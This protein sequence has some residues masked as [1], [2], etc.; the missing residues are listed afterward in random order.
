MPITINFPSRFGRMCPATYHSQWADPA[1]SVGPGRSNIRRFEST[2]P[3][4]VL[5]LQLFKNGEPQDPFSNEGTLDVDIPNN[6]VTTIVAAWTIRY[7]EDPRDSLGCPTSE[8]LKE[9]VAINKNNVNASGYFWRNILQQ[10]SGNSVVEG[11]IFDVY[12]IARC[13][14]KILCVNS[15]PVDLAVNNNVGR[16]QGRPGSYENTESV[17][18]SPHIPI[19][20]VLPRPKV[21]FQS[22]L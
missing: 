5:D 7:R 6:E 21:D 22:M 13:L 19:T 16:F 9:Y 18:F 3:G 15:V 2:G 8:E 20:S 17:K 12:L 1:E 4:K 10:D 11:S 14:E